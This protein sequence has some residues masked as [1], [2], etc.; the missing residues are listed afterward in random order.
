MER[1]LV[2]RTPDTVAA[3]K[4]L[5]LRIKGIREG[6]VYV[7]CPFCRRQAGFLT[8]G[9]SKNDFFC[10]NCFN[11]MNIATLAMELKGLDRKGARALL[12]PAITKKAE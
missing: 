6:L 4:I 9:K 3:I 12:A 7:S 11:S 5:R 2:M 8:K 10:G 1:P